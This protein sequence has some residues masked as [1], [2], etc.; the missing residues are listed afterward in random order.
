M[1]RTADGIGDSA[2]GAPH[3]APLWLP[4]DQ[5]FVLGQDV[6]FLVNKMLD[7]TSMTMLR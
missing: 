4:E 6:R 7:S 2:H 3:L 5:I 1:A